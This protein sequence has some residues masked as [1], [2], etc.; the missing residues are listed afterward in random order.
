MQEDLTDAHFAEWMLEKIENEWWDCERCDLFECR[1]QLVFGEGQGE[2]DLF[3][4]G[5]A[6]GEQ[7]DEE[8]RPFV[9][10]SGAVLR[11]AARAVNLDLSRAYITNRIA[12]RPPKN[13]NPYKNE[14]ESCQ[15]RLNRQISLIRPRVVLLLGSIAA[16]L[17]GIKSI[18][19]E[20]GLV[21]R[22]QWPQTFLEV[23]ELEAVMATFHPSYILHKESRGAKRM[24]LAQ[25]AADLRR[26]KG[27]L[28]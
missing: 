9:G 20:R 1:N 28:G 19:K 4:I 24:A 21:D 15:P 3:I 17:C 13:R 10:P 16:R 23:F 6:P 18:T 25:F 8:G 12:C 7:E 26:T 27:V 14:L 5:E 2:A 22:E 11:K